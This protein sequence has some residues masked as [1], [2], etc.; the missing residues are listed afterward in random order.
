M[1]GYYLTSKPIVVDLLIQLQNINDLSLH[2]MYLDTT[3]NLHM[4]WND[5]RL[6]WNPNE[7]NHIRQ[8]KVIPDEQIW[9]PNLLIG[10][11]SVK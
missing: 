11:Y 2:G 6:S 10:K 4:T 7:F 1:P 5:P 8:I 9:V 3:I